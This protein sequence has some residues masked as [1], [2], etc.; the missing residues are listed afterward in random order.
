M[1][2]VLKR[3]PT[4]NVGD[5]GKIWDSLIFTEAVLIWIRHFPEGDTLPFIGEVR[6]QL[7]KWLEHQIANHDTHTGF[8]REALD[9]LA[10]EGDESDIPLIESFLNDVNQMNKHSAQTSLTKIKKRLAS[11]SEGESWSPRE[12]QSDE[13]GKQKSSS[14]SN[15]KGQ[16]HEEIVDVRKSNFLW[17]VTGL[18][19]LGVIALAFKFY[20]G[21]FKT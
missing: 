14:F 5:S 20:Q 1:L 11:G 17:I 4:P 2:E 18:F 13:R 16:S 15:R 19:I 8:I 7:P 21:N 9:L 12:Q 3:E 6:R 10:R